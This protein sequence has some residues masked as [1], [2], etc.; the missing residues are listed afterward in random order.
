MLAQKPHSERE[1]QSPQVVA[2]THG[3]AATHSLASQLQSVHAPLVGPVESPDTQR[4]VPAHQ[5]QRDADVH[6]SQ[7]VLVAHSSTGVLEHSKLIHAQSPVQVPE[8]GPLESPER[9]APSQKPQP[10]RAVHVSQSVASAHESAG[11]VQSLASQLQSV[12]EPAL[13]PLAVPTPHVPVSP[14]QPQG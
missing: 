13:G 6:D 11:P 12:Q 8:V 1:V 7:S 4:P 2:S 9:H 10:E 5:P 14:H 3:S